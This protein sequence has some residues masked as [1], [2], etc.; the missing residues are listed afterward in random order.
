MKIL[1]RYI[2]VNSGTQ[3][4]LHRKLVCTRK[5]KIAGPS[6]KFLLSDLLGELPMEPSLINC[7][8]NNKEPKPFNSFVRTGHEFKKKQR[9]A[10][11]MHEYCYFYLIQ[12]NLSTFC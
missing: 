3:C 10:V 11:V 12:F 2:V 9:K 5:L 7:Q 4:N 8:E 1:L 6:T